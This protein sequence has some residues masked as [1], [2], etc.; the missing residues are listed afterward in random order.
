MF[1]TI[2]MVS[3][4]SFN[5]Y[6]G[7]TEECIPLFQRY[8]DNTG[9]VQTVSV[10]A[11]RAFPFNFFHEDPSCQAWIERYVV[12]FMH[13][14]TANVRFLIVHTKLFIYFC[15]VNKVTVVY[16]MDGDYGCNERSS[17]YL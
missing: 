13:F 11:V 3:F 5:C 15:S 6:L 2:I 1:D 17:I 12:F 16:W 14:L 7:T 9:D 10:I 8:L 4:F